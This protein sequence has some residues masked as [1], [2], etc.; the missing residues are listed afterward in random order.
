PLRQ[1]NR[2]ARPNAQELD[3]RNSAQLVQQELQLLVVEEQ[4]VAAAQQHIAHGPGSP[5]VLDLLVELRM[6]I[7]A[8]GIADEPRAGAVPAIAGTA[9]GHEEEHAIGVAMH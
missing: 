3:V 7:V 8:G 2:N 9:V 1:K 4:G 5:D 6:K